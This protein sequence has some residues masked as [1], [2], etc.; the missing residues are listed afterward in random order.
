MNKVTTTNADDDYCKDVGTEG[1]ELRNLCKKIVNN[2]KKLSN[3]DKMKK[4]TH[5]DRCLYFNY[6]TYYELKKIISHSTKIFHDILG[7]KKILEVE[8]KINNELRITQ[9]DNIKQY[10]DNHAKDLLL[11]SL[12]SYYG[13]SSYKPCFYYIDCTFDECR[14]MKDLFD[15]FKSYDNIQS[16]ISTGKYDCTKYMQYIH[17][18]SELY[19]KYRYEHNYDCCLWGKCDNYFN[20]DNKFIPQKLYSN[21][22]C[23]FDESRRSALS[24]RMNELGRSSNFLTEQKKS[25]VKFKCRKEY[26]VNGEISNRIICTDEQE[27]DIKSVTLEKSVNIEEIPTSIPDYQ[28]IFNGIFALLGTFFL[29]FVFYKVNRKIF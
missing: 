14:E 8:R 23:A 19:E 27:G 22:K 11:R 5:R 10:D 17:Y 21:L 20:C 2:L 12:N 4:K 9:I 3:I 13:L 24:T 6:W 25:E 26:Q 28:L 15:Y 29:F 18:I 16:T 7:D 1:T